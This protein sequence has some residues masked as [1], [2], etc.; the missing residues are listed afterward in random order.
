MKM[1]GT[2]LNAV[3]MPTSRPRGH[4]VRGSMQSSTQQAMSGIPTWPNRRWSSTGE[5]AAIAPTASTNAIGARLPNRS[6]S[7]AKQ[8]RTTT[9]SS[10][11]VTAVHTRLAAVSPR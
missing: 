2:S 11:T 4:R 1:P 7:G 9:P 8:I 10:T 3:A 6:S 5:R